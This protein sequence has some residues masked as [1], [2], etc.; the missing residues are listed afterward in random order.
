MLLTQGGVWR[1]S[2]AGLQ[3]DS[4]LDQLQGVTNLHD[5]HHQQS[6]FNIIIINPHIDLAGCDDGHP[7]DQ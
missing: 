6:L 1:R 2:Q 5:L 3:A 4:H 7:N